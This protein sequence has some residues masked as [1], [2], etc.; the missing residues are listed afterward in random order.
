M[1]T[2]QKSVRLG[3]LLD[4]LAALEVEPAVFF[5]ELYGL[6]PP[7]EL[8]RVDEL[9]RLESQVKDL[10]VE[11]QELKATLQGAADIDDLRS[12]TLTSADLRGKE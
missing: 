11:V 10:A 5:A 1:M 2:G 4:M 9:A 3:Q 6:E 8:A 7:K 12:W